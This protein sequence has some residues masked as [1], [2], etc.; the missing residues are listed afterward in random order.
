MAKL[1]A[2]RA[3]CVMAKSNSLLWWQMFRKFKRSEV[4]DGAHTTNSH[5][6]L[7]RK[8]QSWGSKTGVLLCGCSKRGAVWR[9]VQKSVILKDGQTHTRLETESERYTFKTVSLSVCMAASLLLDVVQWRN[10][11]SSE[12]VQYK[13][14]HLLC[15]LIRGGKSWVLAFIK[16]VLMQQLEAVG[17]GGENPNALWNQS[18]L[19]FLFK[20]MIRF[21]D[22]HRS[23]FLTKAPSMNAKPNVL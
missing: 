16:T 10:F 19:F 7:Q 4:E 9:G 18:D 15:T 12:R 20:W 17:K 3:L 6:V 14:K 8:G 22:L 21:A 5:P 11:F 23:N 2:E 1:L 13:R